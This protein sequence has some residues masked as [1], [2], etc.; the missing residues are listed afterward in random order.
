MSGDV[1]AAGDLGAVLRV[2]GVGAEEHL[3]VGECGLPAEALLD[4][5]GVEEEAF[6]DHLVVIGAERRDAEF[7]GELHGGYG[8]ALGKRTDA[9]SGGA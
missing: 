5:G 8:G 9:G 4:A 3:F 6:G 1:G 2:V 7:V